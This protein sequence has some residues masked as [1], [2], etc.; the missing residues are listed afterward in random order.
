MGDALARNST[1]HGP[2]AKLED[3]EAGYGTDRG[4]DNRLGVHHVQFVVQGLIAYLGTLGN[5]DRPEPGILGKDSPFFQQ[6][7]R[8]LGEKEDRGFICSSPAF[9]DKPRGFEFLQPLL[10]RLGTAVKV[11]FGRLRR[12]D[13]PGLEEPA[14]NS[15]SRSRMSM[16]SVVSWLS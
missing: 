15:R 6:L 7:N 14:S 13:E 8:L 3:L 5:T 1:E 12:G 11:E 16:G 9:R 10:G 2:S 4:D